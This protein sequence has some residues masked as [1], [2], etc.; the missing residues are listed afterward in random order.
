MVDAE[1]FLGCIHFWACGL[2]EDV[3]FEEGAVELCCGVGKM[4]IFEN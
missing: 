4:D 2:V 1:G 3:F